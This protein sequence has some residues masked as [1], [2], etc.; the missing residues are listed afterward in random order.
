MD[1]ASV[2]QT[3]PRIRLQERKSIPHHVGTGPVQ[4]GTWAR[5]AKEPAC[6]CYKQIPDLESGHDHPFRHQRPRLFAKTDGGDN[7]AISAPTDG[8][9]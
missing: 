5:G 3:N 9:K 8:G 6:T 1:S 7:G 4:V 2:L